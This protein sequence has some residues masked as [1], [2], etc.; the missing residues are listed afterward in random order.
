MLL[1]LSS[2]KMVC[3]IALLALVG[4]AVLYVLAGAKRDDNF[5]YQLLKILTRP[6]IAA[7]RFIT[8]RQVLDAHVPLVA[9]LL[10]LL[11]WA[12]VTFEKIRHCVGVDMVGCR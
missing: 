11:T 2:L 10:L 4:Q 9:F 8:P 7:A 3:E 5:F 1:F 6:F 12:V